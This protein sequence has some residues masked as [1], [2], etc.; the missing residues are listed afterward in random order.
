LRHLNGL[1][2]WTRL[3]SILRVICFGHFF[4]IKRL[5]RLQ[6]LLGLVLSFLLQFAGMFQW[7]MQFECRLSTK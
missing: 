7:C 2:D 5:V 6:I 1:N 3:C 4:S